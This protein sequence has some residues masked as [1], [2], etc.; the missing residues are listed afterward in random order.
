M[1]ALPHDVL[2]LMMQRPDMEWF[3]K[4]AEQG[5]DETK[6]QLQFKYGILDFL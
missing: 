6:C 5:N 3:R 4:A 2:V 1:T